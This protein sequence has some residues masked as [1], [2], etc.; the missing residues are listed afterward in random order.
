M[1]VDNGNAASAQAPPAQTRDL[2]GFSDETQL[3]QAYRN[4]STEARRQKERADALEQAFAN[5]NRQDVNPRGHSRPEDRLSELGIPVDA[6]DELVNQ[7]LQRAFEPLIRAGS[8]RSTVMAQYPDY[9]KYETD[10]AAYLSTDR[11]T[12]EKYNRM[13]AADPEAAMEYAFLSFGEHQRR[14]AATKPNG[15]EAQTRQQRVDAQIPS[16]G[17]DRSRQTQSNEG[18]DERIRKAFEHYQ[19]TGNPTEYAK[20]RL[21]GIFSED[22]FKK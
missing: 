8:A 5:A 7:R 10:V 22:F 14:T 6:L 20:A 16:A 17:G 21:S 15:A 9:Q 3:A 18:A 11:A 1:T 12:Q 13:F 2:A 19:K 4:S